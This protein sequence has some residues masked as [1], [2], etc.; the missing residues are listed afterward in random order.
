MMARTDRRPHYG[1]KRRTRPDGYIDIYEPTHPLA[2]R[3]GYVGEHR[4]L[5]WDAGMFV[6]PDLQVHHK[7]E[8]KTDN[9]IDNFEI[10]GC[11]KHSLDHVEERGWV[12]NQY[13]VW[14]VKPRAL[15]V[16]SPRP[17]RACG[18]C[19]LQVPL[20]RR[21]DAKY[22]SSN[23]RVSAWKHRNKPAATSGARVAETH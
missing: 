5:A 10:K 1:T 8:I 7:N 3:D 14:P 12:E 22:C 13:G 15:R 23:C 11:A 16:N 6:D 17:I 21:R 19:G 20:G 4:K 9:R 18:R 2:R